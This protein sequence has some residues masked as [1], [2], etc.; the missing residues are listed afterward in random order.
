M[1]VKATETKVWGSRVADFAAKP[2][3]EQTVRALLLMVH[4]AIAVLARTRWSDGDRAM[5]SQ[6][7]INALSSLDFEVMAHLDTLNS[8]HKRLS[9]DASDYANEREGIV[10]LIVQMSEE[11]TVDANRFIDCVKALMTPWKPGD[12]NH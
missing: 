11:L 4:V 2:P 1:V 8:L 12:A 6:D 5:L 3:E 9:A 10:A 7:G